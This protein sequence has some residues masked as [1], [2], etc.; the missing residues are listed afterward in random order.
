MFGKELQVTKF[1]YLGYSPNIIEYF[2][3]IGYQESCIPKIID[4]YKRKSNKYSPTILTSITS[5]TDYGMV[6][7]HLIISQ[8]YPDNPLFIIINKND[9]NQEPPNNSNVI[10]YFCFDST[11]GKKKLFYVCFAFKFYE[12]YKY[13]ITKKNYEEY[14]IPKAFCIISQYYY[15]T[16]FD[17]ICKNI[18][19]LASQK[20]KEFPIELTIYNIVNFIPSPINYALN[21]DLFS[22]SLNVPNYEI[23]Q[24][25]GYPYLD[26]DLSEIFNLLPLNL[27]LEIYIL[28]IIEQS[29]IFFS[30][31]LEILN[32]VMF[33]MYILNYP[34]ND[35]TFFWHIVS[36]SKDNFVEE[37]KFVSKVMVS[38]IGVNCSYSEEI[39]TS[40]FGKYHYIVDIDNKKMFLKQAS[41]ML[42]ED[43]I[44]EYTKLS[45]LNTYIE[46]IIREK[47]K[48]IDSL[49]L[50]PFIE[51]LKK[52]LD[53]ILTSD[54]N[55]NPN[56]KNKYVNFFKCSKEILEKNRKIQVLFYDFFLNILMIFYQDNILD[57]S[58]DR[59]KRDKS[60]IKRINKLNS[61]DENTQ[62]NK[63]EKYF[64]ELF[65]Q[66]IKYKVY[67]ENFMLDFEVIDIFKVPFFFSDEFINIKM[68]DLNNKIINKLSLFSIIDSLYFQNNQQT[69]HISMNNIF[70][71]E[72]E[73]LKE[74]FKFYYNSDL[75]TVNNNQLISFNRKIL[76]KYIYLLNTHY[77]IQE[78]M[79]LFPSIRIQQNEY[80]TSFDRRYIINIIQNSLEQ[81]NVIDLSYYLT[82]ALIYVFAISLPI[83]SYLKMV[84]Y[85]EKIIRSLSKTNLFIRQ[86]IY[87]LMKTIYKFY[88]IHK[89]KKIYPNIDVFS[90]K[91]YYYMLTNILIQ[92][93]IIPN[94]EM[95]IILKT[96]FGKIVN[97]E[98]DILNK[99]KDEEI[100]NEANFQIND[101]NFKC[102]M[103]YC[104]TSQ[105]FFKPKTMIKAAMK[106]F[107][108]CNIV[109]RGGNKV[110]QPTVEIR[111][112]DYAYSSYFF[113][114]KKVYKLIQ[115]TFNDFFDNTDLDMNKLKINNVR[116]V[117]ANL[118]LYGFELNNEDD[119]IPVDFLVYTLYLFRN[120]EVKY[121]NK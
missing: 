37:N 52:Y 63:N 62:M 87:I 21:I 91:M 111:I 20:E 115:M 70:L 116:D 38:L 31:N 24:L 106:E 98:K 56:Q 48:N 97:E 117:I 99:K 89:E 66:A 100:D 103:K 74:Y 32:M 58:L 19:E 1:P 90:I 14:Y 46:N 41:R 121:G 112:K 50:K 94:E 92:N 64:C 49:F 107:N 33:I 93:L 104:F 95:M 27:F 96:F 67:F 60:E 119:F 26:F 113:A 22:Y 43:E 79:E 29:I 3:I 15:F 114:P 72:N 82:Y 83:H 69:V 120:Y 57:S 102:F 55:Y 68:K 16:F 71:T 40:P 35:S 23:G 45:N 7:N 4:S 47:D 84:N 75:K 51:R 110:L 101:K 80:I 8:I 61:I 39:R 28:T 76:N 105:K 108:N 36:I 34:C 81:R 9:I 77:N 25:T 53:L 6:D 12:K 30:S 78:L 42:D 54:P 18:Y 88:L 65:R 5:N 2:A 86:H 109:I 118:I 11:D 17:Y 73:K 59:I 44:E 13:Y 85:L 10:Y